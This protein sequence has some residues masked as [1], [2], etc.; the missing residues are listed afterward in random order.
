MKIR[1]RDLEII[2]QK[3]PPKLAP[4]INLEQY[5]T[6]A[7]IAA[8]ILF[9]AYIDGDIFEKM[10]LDLGCGTG[11]FAIGAK[12]LGAGKVIG[13][14]IDC[15]SLTIAEGYANT[16]SL[17]IEFL[18]LDIKEL[19]PDKLGGI[20]FD[21][22]FQNPPFGAQK[23]GRGADR[24]FLEKAVECAKVIYTLHLSKTREFI[25]LL[26][27][28]LGCKILWE[29]EYR[30]PINHMYFFHT[31]ASMDFDVTLLKIGH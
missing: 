26:V 11:I 16:I 18:E 12:L 22:V 21:T 9:S 23:S 30:F 31:K 7:N 5:P 14:D 4:V 13:V 19:S 28:K 6:S 27:D 2:L 8:D 15:T 3:I 10:V 25:E 24:I 20:T 17:D 1:K 29:K